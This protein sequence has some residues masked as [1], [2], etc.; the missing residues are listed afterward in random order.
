MVGLKASTIEIIATR[1]SS[2]LLRLFAVGRE[3]LRSACALPCA[4]PCD[5]P[6]YMF[7]SA[8]LEKRC[9]TALVAYVQLFHERANHVTRIWRL[10]QA[11]SPSAVFIHSQALAW[12]ICSPCKVKPR[13][14]QFA[15]HVGMMRTT[16][17]GFAV[18]RVPPTEAVGHTPVCDAR[19]R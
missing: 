11:L 14:R 7:E 4:H 12:E 18:S 2:D 1:Q 10:K 3:A 13:C 9:D 16:L 8:E 5:V 17:A 19:A 15:P 6:V